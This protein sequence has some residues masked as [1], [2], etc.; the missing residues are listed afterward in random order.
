MT[1]NGTIV[2]LEEIMKSCMD[3]L[4]EVQREDNRLLFVGKLAEY[5]AASRELRVTLRHGQ[6][7]PHGVLHLMPVK[8]QVHPRHHDWGSVVTLYGVLSA[9]AESYWKITIEDVVNRA[10]SRRAFRQKVNAGG[11]VVWGTSPQERADCRLSDIS[12]VGIGFTSTAEL[13]EGGQVMVSVPCLVE[14]A[15]PYELR[16]TLV[17]KRNTAPEDMQPLWYYGGDFG[18][19]DERTES[20]LCK[21]IFALQAKSV[22]RN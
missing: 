20:M 13:P 15:R 6:E 14:N 2:T 1:Q 16:C 18:V 19:L 10:E 17:G 7:T 8:V 12:L 21:D 5:D 4:G 22:R 9:C 11:Q 3:S